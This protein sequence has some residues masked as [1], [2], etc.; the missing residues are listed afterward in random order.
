MPITKNKK[1]IKEF[2]PAA[3]KLQIEKE[4]KEAEDAKEAKEESKT[5]ETSEEA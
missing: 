5:E 3:F 1:E 4:A 2:L